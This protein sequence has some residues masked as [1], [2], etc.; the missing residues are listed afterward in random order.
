MVKLEKH[1]I[2]GKPVTDSVQ[3]LCNKLKQLYVFKKTELANDEESEKSNIK[4]AS[5][6]MSSNFTKYIQKT[7]HDNQSGNQVKRIG[8]GDSFKVIPHCGVRIKTKEMD[9]SGP[10][11][12]SKS[13]LSGSMSPIKK[14]MQSKMAMALKAKIEKS[15][16]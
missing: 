2:D 16:Q 9:A 14:N 5:N 12:T 8:G 11:I 4:D 6:T 10:K 13:Q 1:M 3:V 15:L 7:K